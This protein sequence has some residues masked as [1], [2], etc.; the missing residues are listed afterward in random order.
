MTMLTNNNKNSIIN[1]VTSSGNNNKFKSI[2]PLSLN[3]I[4]NAATNTLM[5]TNQ[6]QQ[7]QPPLSNLVTLTPLLLNNETLKTEQ[8]S[9]HFNEVSFNF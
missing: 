2:Q 7:H 5:D 3:H 1:N 9:H 6:S 4:T 8:D